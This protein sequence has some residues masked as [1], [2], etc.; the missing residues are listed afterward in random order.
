MDHPISKCIEASSRKDFLFILIA[1]ELTKS[2]SVSLF[3]GGLFAC[4]KRQIDEKQDKI[5]WRFFSKYQ[6]E[7]EDK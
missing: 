4:D 1:F 6:Q 5:F 3:S 2:C 7:T